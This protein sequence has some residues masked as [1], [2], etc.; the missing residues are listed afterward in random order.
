VV[1][2][3]PEEGKEPDEPPVSAGDRISGGVSA[4][5]EAVKTRIDE[6][7]ADGAMEAI[8]AAPRRIR[9]ELR[10]MTVFGVLT[11]FP[12]PTVLLCLLVTLFFTYHSGIIDKYTGETSLNVN[13]DLEVYLPTGSEVG[14]NLA[15]VEKDWT[16][17]VMII[18]VESENQGVTDVEILKQ[19]DAI[20]R[21]LNYAESDGGET[22]GII[23]VLSVSTVVKEVNSSAPRVAKAFITNAIGEGGLG[24]NL[25]NQIDALGDTLGGYSIPDEQERVNRIIGELPENAK[26]KLFRDVG[27]GALS[28]V[29]FPNRAVIIVGVID[30]GFSG[31]SACPEEGV[32]E[33]CVPKVCQTP[34]ERFREAQTDIIAYTEC[35]IKQTAM[36]NNWNEAESGCNDGPDDDN[37]SGPS[38]LGIEMTLTGPV[39]IT[40]SVT[41]YSFV[42]FWQIFPLGV[43][44][45]AIGLF[46]FHSDLIQTGTVRPVQG[47]KVVII[48]GLPTLCSVWWSLGIIGYLDYEVTM[49]VIIV[50]PILL[51]LGVS[52]GLHITNRYAEESGT[53]EEKMAIALQSTG[54]AVLLSAVTTVIGFIS[55][56]STPM[57][58]IQTVGISLAGGIIVVYFLTMVMVP[59][60][61]MLLDLKKPSHPP[62]KIV[63]FVVEQPIRWTKVTISIFVILMLVSAVWARTQVE[64]NI[65]LL[66]MAPED[67]PP[68]MKMKQY[69]SE[70]NAGQI[71]MLMIDGYIAGDRDDETSENDDPFAKL[72][73]IE[74]LEN[75]TDSVDKTTAVSIVFLMKSVGVSVNL[76]GTSVL[77]FCDFVPSGTGNEVCHVI[78]DQEHEQDATF[79]RVLT[80][81]NTEDD[82]NKR[83]Q[84]FLLDVFYSSLTEE[85]R[86]L[87]I[88]ESFQR[89][90][91][92]IDMPFMNVQDTKKAV[93][94]VNIY[95]DMNYPGGIDSSPLIGVAAVTIEV[96]ELIVGSQWTSLGFALLA[97]VLTLA[98]FFRDP[99]YAI[100]TTIPVVFTVSMQW[101]VMQ[102]MDVSLSLVTVMIGSILVGVG[103]DF[104]IHIANRVR[105]LGG[106][107]DAIKEACTTTGMS[108]FEAVVVT[109]AGLATAYM[110]P[111]PALKPFVSVIIVL[112]IVAAASALLLLPAIFALFVKSGMGLTGG[113]ASMIRTARLIAKGEDEEVVL[114]PSALGTDHDAW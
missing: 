68:I 17:N 92:Y 74:L 80:T 96:N 45:V 13:G 97:T 29:G 58:P 106:T 85:T 65:D 67:Q 15:E 42:L 104:S 91:I 11:R 32:K 69:S 75:R 61:T 77:P 87:F 88:N 86:Q 2:R 81:F 76:S 22:D 103:V 82:A 47:V 46:L 95:A 109:C 21:P 55:L 9:K 78:F 89:S 108:L 10:Q 3:I 93:D 48:S 112:L 98:I 66:E 64:E 100:L 102:Q 38:C 113:S 57:A 14:K 110:I 37:S 56:V 1:S 111:I 53:P 41:K 79:W 71:G 19:L 26:D 8:L 5:R 70:F 94:E 36:D 6:F 12:A 28:S 107:L 72:Q 23:Y 18:Y 49:T 34:D 63:E 44:A 83:V 101:L 62:P 84:I 30:T 33:G 114:A 60:L 27:A 99:K 43:I 20:E 24:E 35:W 51:A 50:G 25:S 54:K 52:Y 4:V 31:G 105:E 39:P 59:N 90:L 7:D 40:N 16:T 73:D